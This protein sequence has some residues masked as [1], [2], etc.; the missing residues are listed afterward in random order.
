MRHCLTQNHYY[1]TARQVKSPASNAVRDLKHTATQTVTCQLLS[2]T[3]YTV[4]SKLHMVDLLSTYYTSK[5]A[6]N[7]QEIK[8]MKLEP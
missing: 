3:Y 4:K 8:P 6:A 2:H 5:L 1:H 7:I